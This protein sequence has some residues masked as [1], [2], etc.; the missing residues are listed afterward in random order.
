MPFMNSNSIV[1]GQVTVELAFQLKGS[2]ES[3]LSGSCSLEGRKS[4]SESYFP[5]G[6]LKL[7]AVSTITL[8]LKVKKAK[9]E[10]SIHLQQPGSL[11]KLKI[12]AFAENSD[13]TRHSK[14]SRIPFCPTPPLSPGCGWKRSPVHP[15]DVS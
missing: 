7:H 1:L 12:L 8:L 2:V 14:P 6:S 9:H 15:P 5:L 13:I 3:I 10:F 11:G 4:G